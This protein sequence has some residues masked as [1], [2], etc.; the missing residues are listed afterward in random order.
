M[1]T[2]DYERT[3]LVG[4]RIVLIEPDSEMV[5]AIGQILG[6]HGAATALISTVDLAVKLLAEKPGWTDVLLVGPS[7]D[8]AECKELISAI[9]EHLRVTSKVL[10]LVL[11]APFRE[12]ST[13]ET[14]LP[15]LFDAHVPV[16]DDARQLIGAIQRVLTRPQREQ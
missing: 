10:P 11:V 9:R 12:A 16:P 6:D 1:S 15:H 13:A 7:I 4:S 8:T 3:L 2:S 5:R 14:I